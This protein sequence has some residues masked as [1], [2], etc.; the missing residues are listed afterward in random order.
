MLCQAY[1][2]IAL[3]GQA[4]FATIRPDGLVMNVLPDYV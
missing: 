2:A 4:Q 1:R 3:A